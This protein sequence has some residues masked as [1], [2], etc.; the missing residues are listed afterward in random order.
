[1]SRPLPAKAEFTMTNARFFLS[2]TLAWLAIGCGGDEAPPNGEPAW[3]FAA[4]AEAAAF[5]SVHGTRSDDVWMVGADD[6]KGPVVVHYD[7]A[8]W[9]RRETGIRGDLWWVHAI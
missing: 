3:S 1:M 6:G 5:M 7:G 8:A 2:L 4:R 9:E